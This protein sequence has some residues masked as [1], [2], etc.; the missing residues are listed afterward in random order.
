MESPPFSVSTAYDDSLKTT[1]LIFILSPGANPVKFL[2]DFA[3]NMNITMRNISLGQGQ[4]E[5]AKR[6][7]MESIKTGEWVCLENCHLARSWMPEFEEILE[8]V[9][10][11]K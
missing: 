10:K 9:N 5:I 8:E 4:G 7:I 2:R 11:D 6:A 3:K 1:P